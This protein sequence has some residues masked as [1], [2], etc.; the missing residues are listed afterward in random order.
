MK[1][2]ETQSATVASSIRTQQTV[3]LVCLHLHSAWI[4]ARGREIDT[5]RRRSSV[6]LL[7]PYYTIHEMLSLLS[8]KVDDEYIN[9]VSVLDYASIYACIQPIWRGA[10]CQHS[11]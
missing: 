3:C 10:Y 7:C 5:D 4:A 6:S 2:I 1:R 11:I 9:T 8:S